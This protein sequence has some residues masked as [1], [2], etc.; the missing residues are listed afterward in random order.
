VQS[1]RAW[2]EDPG[3]TFRRHVWISPFHENDLAVLKD[4]IG[5]ERI[6][7]GSDWPHTEGLA[8]PLAFVKDLEAADFTSG[9][10]QLVMHDNAAALVRPAS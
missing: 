6:M 4:Q 8:E 2:T 10:I 1:P 7:L 5:A 9:E 3:D